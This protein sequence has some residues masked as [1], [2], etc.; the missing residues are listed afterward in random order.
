MLIGR[1]IAGEL[2]QLPA[3]DERHSAYHDECARYCDHHGDELWQPHSAWPIND[4]RQREGQQNRQCEWNENLSSE[5]KT[6]DNENNA[7]R[8]K[9]GSAGRLGGNRLKFGHCRI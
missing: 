7:P 3:Y 5:I 2:G 1:K 4:A 9:E 6:S 8:C